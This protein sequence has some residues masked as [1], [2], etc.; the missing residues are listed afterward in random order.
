MSGQSPDYLFPQLARYKPQLRLRGKNF[1]VQ[2]NGGWV[3]DSLGCVH[4]LVTVKGVDTMNKLLVVIA[5]AGTL[6]AFAG[7]VLAAEQKL[8]V[9]VE[10]SRIV[11][12]KAGFTSTGIPLRSFA[13]SY[14]VS[15]DDL[16]MTSS[17]GVAAA[18]KRINNAALEACKQINNESTHLF[19]TDQLS[20]STEDCAK[21][22]ARKAMARLHQAIAA[23]A[24]NPNK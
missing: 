19:P 6:G 3:T 9:T 11:E 18:E 24:K 23:A 16:D 15:L 1:T 2:I 21:D 7:G 17:A 20:P 14:E 13:L 4:S 8:K 5:T 22:A 12:E 10:T